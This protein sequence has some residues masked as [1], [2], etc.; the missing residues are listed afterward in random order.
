M[1]YAEAAFFE[2]DHCSH[3][4]TRDDHRRGVDRRNRQRAMIDRRAV[5]R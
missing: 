2:G 5:R 4:A 3:C 1:S